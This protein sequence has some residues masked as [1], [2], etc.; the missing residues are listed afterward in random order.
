MDLIYKYT[1]VLM[2]TKD[3]FIKKNKGIIIVSV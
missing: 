1:N 3:F 2:Q